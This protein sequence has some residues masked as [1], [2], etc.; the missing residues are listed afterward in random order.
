MQIQKVAILGGGLIGASWA[1]LFLSRGL[2]VSIADPR[3]EAEGF[4]RQLIT[5]A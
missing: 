1:A 2:T 5:E 4:C 3:A